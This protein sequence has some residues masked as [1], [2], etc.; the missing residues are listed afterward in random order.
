MNLP[1]ERTIDDLGRIVL[2]RELRK[3]LGWGVGDKLSISRTDNTINM[4]LSKKKEELS[5]D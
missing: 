2:P 5:H 3:E 4:E 1:I